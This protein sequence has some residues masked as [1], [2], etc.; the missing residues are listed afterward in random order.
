MGMARN[1]RGD[2]TWYRVTKGEL[3]QRRFDDHAIDTIMYAMDR[4]GLCR[5]SSR[6]HAILRNPVTGET[7]GV[8][9]DST[10]SRDV[11]RNGSRKIFPTQEIEAVAP[12]ESKAEPE[13][14]AD[15]FAVM[16]PCPAKGSPG[17]DREFATEG[18]RYA[19]VQAEH[20][21]C[22]EEGCSDVFISPRAR[23]GHVG[24]LHRGRH[25]RALHKAAVSKLQPEG[26]D[27][28]QSSAA[29]TDSEILAAIRTALGEDP[30]LL[31]SYQDVERLTGQLIQV[32]EEATALRKERDDL[33]ARMDLITEAT[34]L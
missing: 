30:R 15:E 8:S 7:M 11:T 14:A 28:P 31:A 4:G 6:G 27:R 12:A 18:A 1:N 23:A 2:G 5:I 20:F 32:Q 33:K 3:R 25:P 34:K 13:P 19:H 24:I 29:T 10:K 17:C 26:G 21:T 22:T 16:I 9:P